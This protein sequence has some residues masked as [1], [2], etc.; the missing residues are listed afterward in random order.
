MLSF[1]KRNL[2]ITILFFLSLFVGFLTFLTF[3]KKGEAHLGGNFSM[4]EILVFPHE[5]VLKKTYKLQ[6]YQAIRIINSLYK[7]NINL[8]KLLNN[9]KPIFF[10]YVYISFT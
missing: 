8:I 4:I 2:L 6:Y 1:L 9:N 3:I 7:N 10:I 5:K